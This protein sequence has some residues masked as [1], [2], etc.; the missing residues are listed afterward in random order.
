LFYL[1]A[2]VSPGWGAVGLRIL[3]R[4]LRRGFERLGGLAEPTGRSAKSCP[5]KRWNFKVRTAAETKD[6]APYQFSRERH[7]RTALRT[8][9]LQHDKPPQAGAIVTDCQ[10]KINLQMQ[11]DQI[12]LARIP[13]A[14]LTQ[15]SAMSAFGSPSSRPE[16]TQ[17]ADGAP[18]F[19]FA[20]FVVTPVSGVDAITD[21]G[22]KI[23]LFHYVPS[24]L[25]IRGRQVELRTD[26]DHRE[27]L[28]WGEERHLANTNQDVAKLVRLLEPQPLANCHG[29]VF[30]GGRY[31]IENLHVRDIL[32]DNDYT[33]VKQPQNADLAVYTKDGEITHSG[34]VR[35]NSNGQLMVEGKLGP[36]SVFLHPTEAPPFADGCTFYHSPRR[37][38]VL[39]IEPS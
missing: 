30:A 22:R 29:W 20:A 19:G 16:A 17:P 34:I 14:D 8:G 3:R 2:I 33:I 4:R 11:F 15:R 31:G 25:P 9:D 18:P 39:L 1:L 38:H 10:L 5:R 27:L 21:R 36:F 23:P 26:A 7:A 35:I 12:A 28:L 24:A 37:G 6:L 32:D 13:T